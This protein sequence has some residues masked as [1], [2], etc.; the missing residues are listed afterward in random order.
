MNKNR[1]INTKVIRIVNKV[2][3]RNSQS[4]Q[5]QILFKATMIAFTNHPLINKTTAKQLFKVTR[6]QMRRKM[7]TGRQS[8]I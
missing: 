7:Q 5:V 4:L 6:I 3:D 2:L 8:S 1:Q